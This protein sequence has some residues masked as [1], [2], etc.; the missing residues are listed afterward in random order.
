MS[1]IPKRVV[2]SIIVS[3]FKFLEVIKGIDQQCKGRLP[4][5]GRY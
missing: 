5:P 1:Y 3:S 2:S 4:M